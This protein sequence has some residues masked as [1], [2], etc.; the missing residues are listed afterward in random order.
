MENFIINFVEIMSWFA[1]FVSI[2][3]NAPQI[4]KIHKTRKVEGLSALT[5]SMWCYVTLSLCLRS[6]FI[7][8]DIVFIVSEGFQFFVVLLITI[9]ILKY[10]TKKESHD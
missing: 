7:T 5:Y 9:M 4:I 3:A 8:K 1:L 6:I 2:I 10:K